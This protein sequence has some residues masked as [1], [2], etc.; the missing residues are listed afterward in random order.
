MKANISRSARKGWAWI[1]AALMVVSVIIPTTISTAKAE[2]GAVQF[3]GTA[4]GWLSQLMQN[5]R[6]IK[7]QTDIQRI[8]KKLHSQIQHTQELIMNS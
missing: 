5:G 3:N 7:R 1:L 2:V 6:L 8:S 4:E